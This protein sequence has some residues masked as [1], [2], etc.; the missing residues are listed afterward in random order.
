MRDVVIT[1]GILLLLLFVTLHN[2]KIGTNAG[3][4]GKNQTGALRG[5][6]CIIVIFAHIPVEYSNALQDSLGSFAFIC[7]AIFFMFSGYGLIFGIKNKENYLQAFW[8][9]RI[10]A[11]AVPMVVVNCLD[12]IMNK[13]PLR[14]IVFIDGYVLMLVMCYA[15]FFCVMSYKRGALE[16]KVKFLAGSILLLSVLLFLIEKWIPI[17]VWPVPVVGFAIGAILAVEKKEKI[18]KVLDDRKTLSVLLCFC[19]AVGIAYLK[20]KRVYFVGNY[21]IR[22]ILECCVIGF[23]LGISRKIEIRG[24]I[25]A[26][27]N[28]SY[29]VYLI[30]G[31]VIHWLSKLVSGHSS[32]LFIVEVLIMTI[33]IAE[34]VHCVVSFLLLKNRK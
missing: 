27:G 29:E 9:K 13:Q 33:L 14:K 22:L 7:V 15:V 34:I 16:K 4:L 11:L 25:R 24:G 21:L 10:S 28:I 19:I 18:E 26:I 20:Y 3:Y 6:C 30:H 32:G 31:C 17:T 23:V 1:G 12:I 5:I 8:G 2:V